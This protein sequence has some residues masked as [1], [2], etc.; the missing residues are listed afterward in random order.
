[1]SFFLSKHNIASVYYNL[2]AVAACPASRTH[3]GILLFRSG[4]GNLPRAI[5]SF[6]FQYGLGRSGACSINIAAAKS[7]ALVS[8]ISFIKSINCLRKLAMRLSLR[9]FTSA[10]CPLFRVSTYCTN[11]RS[12]SSAVNGFRTVGPHCGLGTQLTGTLARYAFVKMLGIQQVAARFTTVE[13]SANTT[14][15]RSAA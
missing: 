12:L 1:M 11:R 13:S 5:S 4:S 8:I 7:S 9:S 6:S 15:H 10:S 14:A 3:F 2:R